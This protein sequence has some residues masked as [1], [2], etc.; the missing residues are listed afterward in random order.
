MTDFRDDDTQ[1][2]ED[3]EWNR[4]GPMPAIRTDDEGVTRSHWLGQLARDVTG[5]IPRTRAR[6]FERTRTHHVV[7]SRPS[8]RPHAD[9]SDDWAPVDHWLEPEP[10]QRRAAAAVDPRL[11]RI[12]AVALVGV[13]MIPVA[14]AL[15]EDEESVRADDA[16]VATTVAPQLLAAPT[17]TAVTV[18]PPAAPV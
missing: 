11:V 6:S 4:S 1:L 12:G 7:T 18:P 13:L 5:S 16:R 14:L 3:P 8:E 15:R 2:W 9:A 17:A 10:N